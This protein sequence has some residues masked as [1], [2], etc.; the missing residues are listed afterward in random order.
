M[1]EYHHVG[2][3]SS[4][5]FHW[6]MNCGAKCATKCGLKKSRKQRSQSQASR[7]LKSMQ[8]YFPHLCKLYFSG[9]PVLEHE[10]KGL[11]EPIQEG[12]N[13]K[14]FFHFQQYSPINLN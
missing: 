1:N 8:P 4:Y 13:N 11:L 3:D 12:A 6:M 14:T 2:Y 10:S 7:R 5:L 9:L